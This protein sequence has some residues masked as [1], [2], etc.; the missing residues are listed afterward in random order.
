L[1]SCWIRFHTSLSLQ[2]MRTSFLSFLFP[3]FTANIS[4]PFE[5]LEPL[6]EV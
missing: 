1:P 2:R 4:R 6:T 3:D 5:Y